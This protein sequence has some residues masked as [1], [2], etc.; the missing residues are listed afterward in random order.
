MISGELTYIQ[1]HDQRQRALLFCQWP[2]SDTAGA[3][4]FKVF[5]YVCLFSI[6]FIHIVL[7]LSQVCLAMSIIY[8]GILFC[9]TYSHIHSTPTL[10]FIIFLSVLYAKNS[11]VPIFT[12]G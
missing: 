5:R 10:L 2:E 6:G 8:E 9:T 7:F 1:R 11:L 3:A 4:R 12:G